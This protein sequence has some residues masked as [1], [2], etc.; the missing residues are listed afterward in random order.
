MRGRQLIQRPA[1]HATKPGVDIAKRGLTGFEADEVRHHAAVNLAANTFHRTLADGGFI[2]RQDVAG[3]GANHF[4]QRIRLR[5]GTDGAHMAVKRA[6]GDRHVLRQA[7]TRRPLFA[8]RA[9]GNIGGE[10]VGKQRVFQ[11]FVDDRVEFVEER[12]RRQAAPAF[13]PEGFMSGAAAAAAD[14]LWPRGAREQGGNPVAQFNPGDGCL[15]NR[16]VRA[17]N[18]QDLGPEPFAGVNPANVARVVCFTWLMAQAGDGFGLFHGG[19]VFPQHEHGVRVVGKLRAQRE[20]APFGIH[21][22]GRGA[23]AVDANPDNLCP[24]GLS[25]VSKDGFDCRF[26]RLNVVTRVVTELVVWRIAVAPLLPAR[27][28]LNAGCYLLAGRTVHCQRANR[29]AAKI[30]AN[31]NCHGVAPSEN[32]YGRTLETGGENRQAGSANLMD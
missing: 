26:H 21:R 10:G 28:P 7:E 14:I 1:Q 2:R 25:Q 24:L 19:M 6:A 27:V 20:Y 29:I 15:G 3:G 32:R 22:G 13:V 5:A 18:V 8:K 31:R 11:V 9:D 17:G 12:R 23:S 30:E 4:H 16:C